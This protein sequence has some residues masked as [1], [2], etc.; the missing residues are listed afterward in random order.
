MNDE[1]RRK[2]TIIVSILLSVL[3]LLGL[4]EYTP[5]RRRT[6]LSISDEC[7][8]EIEHI[9]DYGGVSEDCIQE[10]DTLQRK[11]KYIKTRW[12]ELNK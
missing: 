5:T 9:T 6:T 12:G 8:E 3:S 11:L 2:V 1:L 4:I 7:V 10:I